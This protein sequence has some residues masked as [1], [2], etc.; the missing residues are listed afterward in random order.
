MVVKRTGKSRQVKDSEK[1]KMSK[2]TM[3][4]ILAG[5]PLFNTILPGI[6]FFEPQSQFFSQMIAAYKEWHIYDI[7]AGKGH[8]ALGLALNGLTVTAIDFILRENPEY[9][10]LHANA[11]SFNYPH[12][13]VLLFCRP[14]HSEFVEETIQQGINCG[15]HHFVYAGLP[16]NVDSDLGRFRRNFVLVAKK[17]GRDGESLYIMGKSKKVWDGHQ[18][19]IHANRFLRILP[20]T[21]NMKELPAAA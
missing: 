20:R 4:S 1:D 12:D 3:H 7:G 16:K 21:A 15:V 19:G 2:M 6:K 5:L 8:V 10:V 14:C 17:I 13:A 9:P 11:V 18:G